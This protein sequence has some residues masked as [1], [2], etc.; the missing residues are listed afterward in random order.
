MTAARQHGST[1]SLALLTPYLPAR[2]LG[3][4]KRLTFSGNIK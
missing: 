3:V 1:F 4:G 2:S